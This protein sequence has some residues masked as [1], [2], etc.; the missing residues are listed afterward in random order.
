MRL[1]HTER[2]E[3]EEFFNDENIPDY[4]I[5][6]HLWDAADQEVSYIDFLSKT[7]MT[8]TGYAKIL[9]L[10]EK[11]RTYDIK[12]CWIDTCCIVGISNKT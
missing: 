7:K 5:L 10:C 4:A 6:S 12:Y 2:L 3:F 1:L 9:K 8:T 11:A